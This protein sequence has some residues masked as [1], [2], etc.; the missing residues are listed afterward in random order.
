[1]GYLIG[2]AEEGPEKEIVASKDN[3]YAKLSNVELKR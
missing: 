3:P 1:M 2:G